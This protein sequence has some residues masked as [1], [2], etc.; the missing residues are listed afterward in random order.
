MILSDGSIK[1][2]EEI[3]SL[4]KEKGIKFEEKEDQ[5]IYDT[6]NLN[7]QVPS[8][9]KETG[10]IETKQIELAWKLNG[11]KLIK[12]K[13]RGNRSISTTPE[14]KYLIFENENGYNRRHCDS[15]DDYELH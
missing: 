10:K 8:L 2:A 6:R 12:I 1:K 3:F 5:I 9:N 15:Q 4:A 11:G 13:L 7:L 14:H